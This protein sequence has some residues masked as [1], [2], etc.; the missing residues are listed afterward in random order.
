[1][2]EA[3]PAAA[4]ERPDKPT[5]V[6]VSDVKIDSFTVTW[7]PV[8][9]EVFYEVQRVLRRPNG[10]NTVY[11]SSVRVMQGE[12][13]T[14]SS[15]WGATWDVRLQARTW[16]A[17][18]MYAE[19][20]DPVTV[21]TPLPDGYVPPSAPQNLRVAERN[22]RNEAE[23]ITWD[24]PTQGLDPL[25][26]TIIIDHPEVSGPFDTTTQLSY[27]AWALPLNTG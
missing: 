1:M 11:P 19:W 23:L 24:R 2:L 5:N 8:D 3:L 25:T 9:G 15:L 20:S 17:P 4:A 16:W 14:Y 10:H 12:T 26:Y 21:S 22:E 13:V 27:P 7:D 18:V 6:R